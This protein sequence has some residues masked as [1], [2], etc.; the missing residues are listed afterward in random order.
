MIHLFKFFR[1]K[2]LKLKEQAMGEEYN[3]SA[4]RR[5][6]DINVAMNCKVNIDY[7]NYRGERGKR[8]IVPHN[9]W[10]GTTDYHPVPQWLMTAWDI[11]KKALRVFAM[12]DIHSWVNDSMMEPLMKIN[13]VASPASSPIPGAPRYDDPGDQMQHTADGQ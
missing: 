8:V 1:K 4:P 5:T 3:P 7:T 12:C 10:H 11:E 2:P 13:V 6:T 9:I